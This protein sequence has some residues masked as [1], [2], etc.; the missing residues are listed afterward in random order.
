MLQSYIKK[1]VEIT[2]YKDAREESYYSTLEDLLYEYSESIDE[3]NKEKIHITT[4]PKKTNKSKIVLILN[5]FRPNTFFNKIN[6]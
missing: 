5:L 2:N 3:K 6:I 1:I 4:I